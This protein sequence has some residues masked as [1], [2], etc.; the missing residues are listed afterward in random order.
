MFAYLGCLSNPT[1]ANNLFVGKYLSETRENFGR[2]KLGEYEITVTSSESPDIFNITI[3]QNSK[4]KYTLKG[5]PCI[6]EYVDYLNGRPEGK[7]EAL[8]DTDKFKFPI[9]VF[10]EN[11]IRNPAPD[12]SKDPEKK[13]LV[14]KILTES[15]V[16][17]FPWKPYIK[18]QYY[19][20]VEWGFYGF[21]KVQ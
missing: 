21:R 13:K 1:F 6:P 11:G 19:A 4:L 7:A 3:A 15:G 14:D 2:D 17:P 8:C 9:L 5:T 16:K 12:H 18:T 10:A 20:Y